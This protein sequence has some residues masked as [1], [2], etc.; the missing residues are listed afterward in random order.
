[1]NPLL[2]GFIGE[3]RELIGDMGDVLALARRGEADAQS[4]HRLFRAFHTIKGNAGLF[5][6]EPV[7]H[8]T[9]NG[10]TVLAAV[11]DGSLALD[12][13]LVDVLFEVADQLGEWIDQIEADAP[14]SDDAALQAR[15]AAHAPDAH[16]APSER[17]AP[18]LQAAWLRCLPEAER[19][20]ALQSALQNQRP[21]VL[22]RYR[23]DEGAFFAGEDPLYNVRQIDELLALGFIPN[24][25]L[26]ALAELDPFR[27]LLTW[28][29]LSHSPA[30]AIEK[31][32][33]DCS[34]E[35]DLYELQPLQL[36][37]LPPRDEALA[38]V[39]PPLLQALNDARTG[40]LLDQAATLLAAVPPS[41]RARSTALWL[42]ALVNA[43]AAPT[44]LRYLLNYAIQ[45]EQP[46]W[47]ALTPVAPAPGNAASAEARLPLHLALLKQQR[48]VLV[49][50]AP[51]RLP[52][53]LPSVRMVVTNVAR[54]LDR[55]GVLDG[56][57]PEDDAPTLQADALV[58]AITQLLQSCAPDAPVAAAPVT[59]TVSNERLRIGAE[60]VDEALGLL[61][62][63][64]ITRHTLQTTIN[65]QQ[66][67][68]AFTAPMQQL[69][70]QINHL[71][72]VVQ[73]MRLVPLERVFERLPRLVRSL[74]RKLGKPVDFEL[75]GGE[76]F[77]DKAVVDALH[78]PLVHL[79]RNALDHGIEDAEVRRAS[80]KPPHGR[81]RV[82]AQQQEERVVLEISDDGA[83]IDP[84]KVRARAR[85][86][87]LID[88]ER[89]ERI[90]DEALLQLVFEPGF[91]TSAAVS[92]IS[93][94]GVGMDVVRTTLRQLGGE[95]QLA[96]TPGQGTRISLSMPVSMML[97]RVL[98][99][100]AGEQ[101]F[102]LPVSS[103]VE[104][105]PLARTTLQTVKGAQTL[106]WRE[107]MFA[108]FDLAGLLQLP[109]GT[110]GRAL[111]ITTAPG[112]F[113]LLVDQLL[114]TV[115]VLIRPL[116]GALAGLPQY[117]GTA[118]AGTG[119]VFLVLNPAGLVR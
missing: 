86:Q 50:S 52:V 10:E 6:Y 28:F 105:L 91:S 79:L 49:A 16:A 45:N 66:M 4:V 84:A 32:K 111:Q 65:A 3:S 42:E 75:S 19:I 36:I 64:L 30:S 2:A 12:T 116:E 40:Q 69:D 17:V 25:T 97:S 85:A 18:P 33:F 61:S 23:P 37:Q 94:R 100:R 74:E 11:R 83:G 115:D 101:L 90:D 119:E 58:A 5:D 31:I 80:G 24:Q 62:E 78:E 71:L 29:A 114:D 60:Q 9:H 26:P 72:N 27:N 89:A 67:Q 103:L 117:V 35:F 88:A 73:K 51:E 44:A 96:S 57:R 48:D 39:L 21:L 59:P 99:V 68:L 87:G 15:L 81:L 107:Q 13:A 106:V 41:P 113:V 92:E 22:L 8:L 118:M 102:G 63:L 95:V 98:L 38:Q 109:A 76:A 108:V 53:V 93:G 20:R 47:S 110:R 82:Q 7:T 43:Q 56:V 1:M 46:D 70:R 54:A 112:D 34:G 104:S 77:A 14:L 55:S